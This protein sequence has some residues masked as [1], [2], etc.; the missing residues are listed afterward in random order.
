[1][2]RV[3]AFGKWHC[4][5]LLWVQASSL[6][7]LRFVTCTLHEVHFSSGL[8]LANATVGSVVGTGTDLLHGDDFAAHVL[9]DL[10]G[11]L[12]A[13]HLRAGFQKLL[14]DRGL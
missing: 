8:P 9:Q 5:A 12:A 14:L 3:K 4:D 1:M 10:L 7:Q 13:A 2:K 11:A 6:M